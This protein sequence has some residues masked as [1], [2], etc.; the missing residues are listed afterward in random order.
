[1][2]AEDAE[3]RKPTPVRADINQGRPSFTGAYQKQLAEEYKP[4]KL[5]SLVIGRFIS[6]ELEQRARTGLG[7]FL[8]RRLKN[9][10]LA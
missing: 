1:M 3:L 9:G 5:G 6:R 7:F 2:N 4:L 8:G 10:F